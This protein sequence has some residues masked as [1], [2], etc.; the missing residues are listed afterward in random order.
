MIDRRARRGGKEVGSAGAPVIQLHP[1]AD[2]RR[3][4]A[5]AIRMVSNVVTTTLAPTRLMQPRLPPE[6]GHNIITRNEVRIGPT[7]CGP[8][9]FSSWF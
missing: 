5:A 2:R 1:A 9:R 7:M 4:D 8:Q 3:S 6:C